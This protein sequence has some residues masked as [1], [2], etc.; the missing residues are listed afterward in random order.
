MAVP[1]GFAGLLGAALGA[2]IGLLIGLSTNP[3]AAAVA[4]GLVALLA[5]PEELLRL[6]L[7]AVVEVNN[8]T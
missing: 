6:L 7:R 3:I 1:A 4:S 8:P 2:F 5:E